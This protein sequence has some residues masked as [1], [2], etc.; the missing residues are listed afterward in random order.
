[1]RNT[2]FHFASFT[3]SHGFLFLAL[4]PLVPSVGMDPLAAPS[5]QWQKRKEEEEKEDLGGVLFSNAISLKPAGPSYAAWVH[6]ERGQ[7]SVDH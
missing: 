3:C 5:L 2:L 7:M 4:N 6:P 1:M